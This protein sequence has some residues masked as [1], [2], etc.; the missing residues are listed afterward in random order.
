MNNLI[1][2]HNTHDL[3]K[4]VLHRFITNTVLVKLVLLSGLSLV[5]VYNPKVCFYNDYSHWPVAYIMVSSK[6]LPS[7]LFHNLRPHKMC[8]FQREFIY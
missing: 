8:V 4:L 6:K 1:F 3:L 7:G 5:A 2:I